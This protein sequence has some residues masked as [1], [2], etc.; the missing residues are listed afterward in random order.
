MKMADTYQKT[1][2][3][4]EDG[5]K[6]EEKSMQILDQTFHILDSIDSLVSYGNTSTSNKSKNVV[7]PVKGLSFKMRA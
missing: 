2:P 4:Q 7:V 1:T 6:S 3:S 5:K